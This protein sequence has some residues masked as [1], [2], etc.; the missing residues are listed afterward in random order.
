MQK[1]VKENYESTVEIAPGA[2][3]KKPVSKAL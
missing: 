3:G 2:I 1:Y